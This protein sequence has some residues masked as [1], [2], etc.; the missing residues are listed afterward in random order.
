MIPHGK[1]RT[2]VTHAEAVKQLKYLGLNAKALLIEKFR[3]CIG[4]V[5]GW[6]GYAKSRSLGLGPIL[7]P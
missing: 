7:W 1:V 2:K 6:D 3:N 4:G 5:G